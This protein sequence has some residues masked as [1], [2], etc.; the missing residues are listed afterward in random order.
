MIT[1]LPVDF[2]SRIQDGSD[3]SISA[4]DLMLNF[5]AAF[6]EIDSSLVTD[7]PSPTGHTQ[8]RLLIPGVPLSGNLVLSATDGG[9]SWAEGI[10]TPPTTGTYVLGVVDGTIQW[11]ATQEC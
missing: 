3:T 5:S 10:P 11:I 7:S 8:R 9:L 2:R 6:I 4:N 1:K